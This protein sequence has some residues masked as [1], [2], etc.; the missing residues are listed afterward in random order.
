MN[1]KIYKSYGCLA[2]EK[3]PVYSW[4]CPASEIYDVID[5]D[6]DI[7]GETEAGEPM[8]HLGRFDYTLSEVLGNWGDAPAL[9]W[10]DG[11]SNRHKLLTVKA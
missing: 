8:V 4:A 7:V 5:V 6:L 2:H 3:Q 1:V 11:S 10:F 9:I